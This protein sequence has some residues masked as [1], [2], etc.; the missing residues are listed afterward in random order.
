MMEAG[1]GMDEEWETWG[2]LRC[3]GLDL[4]E[5]MATS[6]AGVRGVE[7]LTRLP[8]RVDGSCNCMQRS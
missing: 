7:R 5:I 4:R 2:G 6:S 8:G 3:L 1:K